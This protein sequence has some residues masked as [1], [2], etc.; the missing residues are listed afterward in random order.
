LLNKDDS[1]KVKESLNYLMQLAM[2]IFNR[3]RKRKVEW[4]DTFSPFANKRACT[5]MGRAPSDAPLPA[6]GV[7]GG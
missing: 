1:E 2:H 6:V 4:N 5:R 7:G 3:D